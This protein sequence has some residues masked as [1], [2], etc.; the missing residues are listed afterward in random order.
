MDEVKILKDLIKIKSFLS[1]DSNEIKLSNYIFDMLSSS[2]S[3]RVEKQFIDKSSERFNV[4]AQKGNQPN[5]LLAAHIDTVEPRAEWTTEP[6]SPTVKGSRM[7]GLGSYDNKGGAA[8]MLAAAMDSKA[9]NFAMLFYCD[10]EYQFRGM[11]NFISNNN[12]LLSSI[13]TAVLSEPTQ[14]MIRKDHRG[15]IEFDMTLR[16]KSGHAADL[17][18]GIN[19]INAAYSILEDLSKYL[20]RFRNKDLG[21]ST[22]NVA[23]IEGGLAVP[24]PDGGLMLSDQGNNIAD[25]CRL[26]LE[27]RTSSEKLKFIKIIERLKNITNILGVSI[28]K[29]ELC[30][31]FGPLINTDKD[32]ESIK[33]IMNNLGV[34]PKYISSKRFGFGDGQFIKAKY[35]I[36]TIY[37]GPVGANMHSANEWVD[38]S[39]VR[40]LKKIY[41][42]L[43]TN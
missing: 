9:D 33:K 32:L 35:D 5:I 13:E 28:D 14:L 39:S 11:T 34:P 31:E 42:D 1:E 30:K 25:Y 7:Y 37:I 20:G 41:S 3:L 4:L 17:K 16:G 6:F 26:R 38:V 8:A 21:S 27:I 23:Y 43:L 19:A 2:K 15:I 29:L 40:M 12:E 10:E 18:S 22:L 36:P 24:Q